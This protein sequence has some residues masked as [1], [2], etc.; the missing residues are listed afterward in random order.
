MWP[1]FK[2]SIICAVFCVS[3]PLTLVSKSKKKIH[4]MRWKRSL[5][6]MM[7]IYCNFYHY[8]KR[9]KSIFCRSSDASYEAHVE[10]SS[11]SRYVI[12]ILFII[13]CRYLEFVFYFSSTDVKEEREPRTERYVFFSSQCLLLVFYSLF[14]CEKQSTNYRL[15]VGRQ[16]FRNL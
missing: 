12:E 7:G 5:L 8:F 1:L 4:I 14:T 6:V 11:N 10:E 13:F 2:I 16:T 9:Y 3:D 15:N